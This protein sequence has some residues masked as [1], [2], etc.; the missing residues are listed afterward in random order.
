MAHGRFRRVEVVRPGTGDMGHSVGT[1]SKWV[2][3]PIEFVLDEARSGTSSAVLLG[4]QA[5]AC[6]DE[7]VVERDSCFEDLLDVD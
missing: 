3:M 6:L 4:G 5:G 2:P 1:D 7:D